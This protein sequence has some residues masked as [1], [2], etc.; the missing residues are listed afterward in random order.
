LHAVATWA[1]PFSS[2]VEFGRTHSPPMMRC[3]AD[4]PVT[5][6][7]GG[8]PDGSAVGEGGALGSMGSSD[9]DELG[10]AGGGLSD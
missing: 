5:P 4:Q 3:G 1:V 2:I 10:A 8:V 7:P 9:G 6:P